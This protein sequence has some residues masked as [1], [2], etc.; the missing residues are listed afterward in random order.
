MMG[1]TRGDLDSKLAFRHRVNDLGSS[2][3]LLERPDE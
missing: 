1:R 2:I 3:L